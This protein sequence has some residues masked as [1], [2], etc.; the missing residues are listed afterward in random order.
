MTKTNLRQVNKLT[1]FPF[2]VSHFLFD[3]NLFH[4]SG[5]FDILELYQR[6]NVRRIPSTL[7][8]KAMFVLNRVFADLTWFTWKILWQTTQ[9]K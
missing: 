2:L 6:K 1:R 9:Y 7:S 3:E 5:I 8:P 4:P